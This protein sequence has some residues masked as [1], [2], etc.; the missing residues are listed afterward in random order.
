MPASD[1]ETDENHGN[2]STNHDVKI[3]NQH[4]P[5]TICECYRLKAA[6]LADDII[7][8]AEVIYRTEVVCGRISKLEIK[9]SCGHKTY[10][11]LFNFSHVSK[12]VIYLRP[13]L[14]DEENV[15][16][17]IQG[18]LQSGGGGPLSGIAQLT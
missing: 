14:K 7:S 18:S 15:T 4:L 3:R 11:M 5:N 1:R 10:T 9:M 12:N 16:I 2:L 6:R 13:I 8:R 17:S